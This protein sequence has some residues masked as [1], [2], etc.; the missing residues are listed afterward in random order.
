ML[1]LLE[2]YYDVLSGAITVDEVDVRQYNLKHLRK[3]M[4]LVGQEPTLFNLTIREN[5]LYG[6]D[7]DEEDGSSGGLHWRM[8][9]AAK[10]A[11]IHSFI[12]SLPSGYET[13]VIPPSNQPVEIC[14]ALIRNCYLGRRARRTPVRWPEATNRHRTSNRP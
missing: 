8:I 1:S 7:T 11:N 13:K 14:K 6:L 12:E 9:E 3:A 4:S 10:L 5:I 2:R